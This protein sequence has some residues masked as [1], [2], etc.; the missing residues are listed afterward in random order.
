MTATTKN[1]TP[2][3]LVALS[4]A[5]SDSKGRKAGEDVPTG[6]YNVDF[7]VHVK[8]GVKRGED[9][10]AVIAQR[11]AP[12]KLLAVALN[13]L[14]GVTVRDIVR[15]AENGA[16]SEEAQSALKDTVKEALRDIKGEVIGRNRGKLTAAIVVELVEGETD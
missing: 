4:K 6:E 16:V 11:A 12:W 7:T 15:E 3:Q 1:L 10:D 8:G 5:V 14:N 2:V 9:Y 13:H